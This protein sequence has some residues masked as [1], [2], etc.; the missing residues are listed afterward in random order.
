M[1]KNDFA[2]AGSAV[3]VLEN[4]LLPPSFFEALEESGRAEAA[5]LLSDQGMEA[6]SGQPS[7]D[8]A[9][10]ILAERLQRQ[11][12]ELSSLLDEKKA[13]DFLIVENDFHNL[14]AALL[15]VVL[16][17]DAEAYFLTPSVLDPAEIGEAVKE[18]KWDALPPFLSEAA[19]EGYEILTS[20]MDSA[21][22]RWYLDAR[23]A[24]TVIAFAKKTGSGTALELAKKEADLKNYKAAGTLAS[25]ENARQAWI[26]CAFAEGGNTPAQ[27]WKEAVAKKDRE[28][29]DS[30]F[31]GEGG[32]KEREEAFADFCREEWKKASQTILTPDAVFAYF[33]A[34]KSEKT[35]IGYLWALSEFSDGEGR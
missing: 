34:R 23:A 17:K 27:A 12:E 7:Q 6:F 15:S 5:R 16:K 1:K 14:K 2:F 30:F 25:F 3:R 24:E 26:D 35:R 10:E 21:R 32:A 9:E 8:E 13:L 11:Y 31:P 22:L 18:K 29:I 20:G 28:A 4:S 19:K 33:A